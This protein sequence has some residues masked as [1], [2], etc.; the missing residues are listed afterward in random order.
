MPGH[1][2]GRY[3]KTVPAT[4]LAG[5]AE[6]DV[7]EITR[8]V[9]LSLH[10][11]ESWTAA[12]IGFKA[13]HTPSGDFYPVYNEN[14]VLVQISGADAQKVYIAPAEAGAPRYIK[15]WSQN[16]SGTDTNQATERVIQVTAKA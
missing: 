5:E 6:S 10:M 12:S 1:I 2:I 9:I 15:L 16:G 13:C 7:L 14:D 8:S 11:P 3:C 4:I